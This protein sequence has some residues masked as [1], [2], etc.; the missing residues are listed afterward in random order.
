MN[1]DER[2]WEGSHHHPIRVGAI[3]TLSLERGTVSRSG[4]GNPGAAGEFQRNF[5]SRRA[6]GR[7]PALVRLGWRWDRAVEVRLCAVKSRAASN[8]HCVV[9]TRGGEQS[10]SRGKNDQSV[11]PT[12]RVGRHRELDSVGVDGRVFERVTKPATRAIGFQPN[13]R[14]AGLSSRSLR[15]WLE[16]EWPAVPSAVSRETRR[17]QAAFMARSPEEPPGGSQ[18]VRRSDEAGNDRGAKGRRKVEAR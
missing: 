14:A 6:A 17:G 11:T 13:R 7:S 9:A 16:T 2:R 18:S 4:C 10:R 15:R 1:A 3:L 5:V 8:R 12:A